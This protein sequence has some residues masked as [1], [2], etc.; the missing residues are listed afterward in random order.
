VSLVELSRQRD[1]LKDAPLP[2]GHP[3]IAQIDSALKKPK[4]QEPEFGYLADSQSIHTLTAFNVPLPICLS[5]N[6]HQ[7]ASNAS[8]DIMRRG[9]GVDALLK[10]KQQAVRATHSSLCGS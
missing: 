9:G 6:P 7:R 4:Q 5:L 2:T 10:S 8:S 3:Q 1:T